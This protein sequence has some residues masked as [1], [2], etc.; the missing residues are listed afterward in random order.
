MLRENVELGLHEGQEN[1]YWQKASTLKE[2]LAVLAS[3]PD[4]ALNQA[5]Q[6][7]VDL[8]KTRENTPQEQ[9]RQAVNV[10]IR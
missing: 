1:Q 2:K 7:P 10:M 9:R 4:T 8:P 6:T 5:V 3:I